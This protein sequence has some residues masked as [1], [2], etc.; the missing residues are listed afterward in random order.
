[1]AH[2]LGSY[3]EDGTFYTTVPGNIETRVDY[4]SA[5]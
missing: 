5:A 3:D 2:R 4:P 1:M